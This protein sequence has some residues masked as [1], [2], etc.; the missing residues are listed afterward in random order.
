MPRRGKTRRDSLVALQRRQYVFSLRRT[1]ASYEAIYQA[2]VRRFGAELPR[3]YSRWKVYQDVCHELE[4]TREELADDVEAVRAQELDRLDHLQLAIWP[5][6]IGRPA[7]LERGLPAQPPDLEAQR[8]I[9]AIQARR[10]KYLPGLEVPVKVAPTTPDG[11]Q[12]WEPTTG[13]ASLLEV[14]RTVASASNGQAL[15]SQIEDLSA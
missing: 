2:T 14:A 10:A 6:A 1:G 15:P 7:D 3:H 5:L 8:Q 11:L 13:L 4:R 9:L 12:G